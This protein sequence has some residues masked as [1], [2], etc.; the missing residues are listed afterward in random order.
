MRVHNLSSLLTAL[1]SH[2][3]L[4]QI[5]VFSFFRNDERANIK[6]GA[7]KMG[8]GAFAALSLQLWYS[9]PEDII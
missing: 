5:E 8:D 9:L 4:A 2:E 3:I 7:H 1:A 6:D